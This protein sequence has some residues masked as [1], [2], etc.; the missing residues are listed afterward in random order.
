MIRGRDGCAVFT[1]TPLPLRKQSWVDVM[2][3]LGECIY[4][5]AEPVEGQW[6]VSVNVSVRK[7]I[8]M[9]LVGK[10]AC[11]MTAWALACNPRML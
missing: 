11:V 2:Q 5:N 8:G 7:I 6:K 9:S 10:V 1:K 3:V 4:V